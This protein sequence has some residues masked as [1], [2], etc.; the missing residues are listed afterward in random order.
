MAEIKRSGILKWTDENVA[1]VPESCGVY[2]LRPS[3]GSIGYIGMAGPK[4]LRTRLQKH[5]SDN[6]HPRTAKFDW[7]QTSDE[8]SASTT[9]KAWIKK[10]DPPWNKL[11]PKAGTK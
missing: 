7:Y 5:K 9:E 8:A 11:K 3:D 2:I 6:D 4:Q 1:A 10:H